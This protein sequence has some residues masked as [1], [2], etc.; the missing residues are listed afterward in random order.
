M[1]IIWSNKSYVCSI[2]ALWGVTRS[3]LRSPDTQCKHKVK[4]AAVVT[5]KEYQNLLLTNLINCF[6]FNYLVLTPGKVGTI[7]NWSSS[8]FHPTGPFCSS[9]ILLGAFPEGLCSRR[10][11]RPRYVQSRFLPTRPHRVSVYDVNRNV[12]FGGKI[13]V[14]N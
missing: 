7:P 6:P 9:C 12:E 2:K 11:F 1:K 10:R 4:A 3:L 13:T 8:I 14:L 5:S